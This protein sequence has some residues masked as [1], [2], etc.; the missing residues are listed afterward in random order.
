MIRSILALSLI[1][2]LAMAELEQEPNNSFAT[3][4]EIFSNDEMIGERQKGEYDYDYYTFIANQRSFKLSFSTQEEQINYTVYIYNQY[5]K[6]IGR[7]RISAGGGSIDRIIGVNPGRVYIKI[8]AYNRTSSRGTYQL[9]IDTFEGAENLDLYEIE[10]NN[11]LATSQPILLNKIYHGYREYGNYDY[12]FYKL[13]NKNNSLSIKF[14]TTEEYMTFYIRVYDKYQKEIKRFTIPKGE[15]ELNRSFTAPLG[16]IYVRVY[17]YN[18]TNSSGSY[19]LSLNSTSSANCEVLPL[20]YG[21]P[22]NGAWSSNCLSKYRSGAYGKSFT[23]TLNSAQNIEISL[24]SNEDTYLNLIDKSGNKIAYNDDSD[25]TTNSKIKMFLQAGEYRV[26]ATTYY[27]STL[28]N[29]TIKYSA[30]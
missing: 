11:T 20:V 8:Y 6:E 14:N 4:Q 27:P 1:V 30:K 5:Q 3:A 17:G 19:Q 16:S 28:G 29:F 13:I 26:E 12:D 25:G 22:Y 2:Q 10:P 7:Y 24:N 15:L 23:F 9:N 18:R 21:L